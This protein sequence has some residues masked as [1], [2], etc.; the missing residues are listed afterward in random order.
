VAFTVRFAP[1]SDRC[2][3]IADQQLGADIVEKL[4]FLLRS[5]FLWQLAGF[6]KNALW[7]SA[8]TLTF[9]RTAAVMDW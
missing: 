2:A 3:D 1:D 9:L 6:K 4:D 5:Q 7:G 8:E